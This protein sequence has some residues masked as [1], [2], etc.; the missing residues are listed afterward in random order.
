MEIIPD[1]R[2]LIGLVEQ[3]ENGELCL[4]D[5][6]RNFV[7]RRD[8]VADL[9]RSILEALLYRIAAAV[10]LRPSRTSLRARRATRSKICVPGS[11]TQAARA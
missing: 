7:W 8:E 5:F 9:L 2:K 4:P 3:A 6:Q 11:A 10:A 1:K